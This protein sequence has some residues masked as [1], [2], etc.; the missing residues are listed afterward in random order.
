MQV[1]ELVGINEGQIDSLVLSLY[2]CIEKINSCLNQ[3]DNKFDSLSANFSC[4]TSKN[5]LSKYASLS[6]QFPIINGN[7][8]KYTDTLISTKSKISDFNSDLSVKIVRNA[9]TVK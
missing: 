2:N 5:I 8:L 1:Q 9:G 7:L 6:S 4:G 3:I